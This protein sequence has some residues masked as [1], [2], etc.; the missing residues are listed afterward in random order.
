MAPHVASLLEKSAD[1][2]HA[3]ELHGRALE[4]SGLLAAMRLQRERR[5]EARKAEYYL[6]SREDRSWESRMTT[7]PNV[8]RADRRKALDDAVR[9]VMAFRDAIEPGSANW[10]AADA[11]VRSLTAQR[12]AA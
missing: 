4:S 3:L 8:A 11:E 2:D 10:H 12:A 9:H 7:A 6:A 5:A 1:H